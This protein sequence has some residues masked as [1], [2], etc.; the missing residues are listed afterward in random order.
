M[1]YSYA[2]RLPKFSFHL[3]FR[4]YSHA[5][6]TASVVPDGPTDPSLFRR[7]AVDRGG[8][9]SAVYLGGTAESADDVVEFRF[10]S[11]SASKH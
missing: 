3:G 9:D 8:P 6:M 11:T 7:R 10:G 1:P 4:T 5:A 2:R